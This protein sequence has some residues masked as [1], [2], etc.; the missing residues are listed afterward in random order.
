[1]RHCPPY[2]IN[3]NQSLTRYSRFHFS[4]TLGEAHSR[5][6]GVVTSD[7]RFE[8]TIATRDE[9]YVIEKAARY[10]H[11]PQPFHSVIYKSSDVD[12]SKLE[13]S[14][15]K[16]DE[17]HRKLRAKQRLQEEFRT[18][19]REPVAKRRGRRHVDPNKVTCTLYVQADHLFYQHFDSDVET[20]VEQ[21]TEHVQGVNNIFNPVGKLHPPPPPPPFSFVPGIL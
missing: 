20:V 17:I 18:R 5:V 12:V 16:S 8:G 7:G 10:F 15:C 19:S 4:V 2:A 9:R 6:Y 11:D 1:M 21:M 3:P 14:L 13:S